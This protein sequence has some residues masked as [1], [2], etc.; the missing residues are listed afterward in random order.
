MDLTMAF[1]VVCVGFDDG[2]E[3][4]DDDEQTASVPVRGSA[5]SAS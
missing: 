3:A 4:G 1:Q 2:N 5:A